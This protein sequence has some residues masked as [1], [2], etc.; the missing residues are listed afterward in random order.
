MKHTKSQKRLQPTSNEIIVG[1][2]ST[3]EEIWID[4]M[5]YLPAI[6][7]NNEDKE[8]EKELPVQNPPSLPCIAEYNNNRPSKSNQFQVDDS[9]NEIDKTNGIGSI[10]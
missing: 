3:S 4:G 7:I 1:P 5:E 8:F 6:C 2:N 10:K 9:I